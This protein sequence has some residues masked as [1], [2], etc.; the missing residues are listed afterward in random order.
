M[1]VW[2]GFSSLVL[3]IREKWSFLY[4]HPDSCMVIS[5]KSFIFNTW[6]FY[7]YNSVIT[8]KVFQ[9][10]PSFQMDFYY[11]SMPDV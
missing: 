10:F 9:L 6:G 3:D 4:V 2:L 5:A 1:F 8:F 11:L 7:H